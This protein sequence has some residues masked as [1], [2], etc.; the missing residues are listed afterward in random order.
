MTASF[1]WHSDFTAAFSAAIANGELLYAR[2]AR[3]GRTMGYRA[4]VCACGHRGVIW[5]KASGRARLL[6]YAVYHQAYGDDRPLPHTVAQ[7]ELDE[8]PRLVTLLDAGAA[9]RALRPGAPL[10]LQL[11]RHC[12]L[13]AHSAEPSAEH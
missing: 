9:A 4:R 2:C 5:A 13:V 3:C 8:G 7:V 12:C 6:S 11:D 1:R 10:R